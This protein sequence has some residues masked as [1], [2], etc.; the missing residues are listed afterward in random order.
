MTATD[1]ITERVF[2]ILDKELA[3]VVRKFTAKLNG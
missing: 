2:Q 1:S 3:A